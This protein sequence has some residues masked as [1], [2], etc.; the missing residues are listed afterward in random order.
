MRYFE[1]NLTSFQIW[2]YS[3]VPKIQINRYLVKF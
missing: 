3:G 1:K 2:H